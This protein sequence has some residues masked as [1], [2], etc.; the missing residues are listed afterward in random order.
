MN[1]IAAYLL[2]Y[3]EEEEAYL[4]LSQ[5]LWMPPYN[6]MDWFSENIPLVHL[7]IFQVCVFVLRIIV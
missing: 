6:M 2:N 7:A 4:C 5:L 1:Y 3:M